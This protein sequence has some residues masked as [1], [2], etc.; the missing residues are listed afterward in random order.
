MQRYFGRLLDRQALLT[1]DDI[2]H[3]LHVMRQKE[4]A[5]FELVS[6]GS[7]FLCHILTITPFAAEVVK[8]LSDQRKGPDITL[9]YSLP[10]GEKLDL[11]LQKAT[12]LGVKNIILTLTA[13]SIVRMTRN[14]FM[15][16]R[17]RYE[18]IIKE[19]AEQSLRL[20]MPRLTFCEKLREAV[21]VT[22]GQK[23]IADT[24]IA[25]GKPLDVAIDATEGVALLI[26]PEGGFEHEEVELAK[27]FG[28]IPVSLGATI[29]RTETAVIAGLA[30]LAYKYAHASI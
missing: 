12:E 25:N 14:D 15:K 10:K 5:E 19:A 18:R 4:G 29:L 7:L 9:I 28:F 24:T 2:H 1:P 3:L 8:K 16:K 23:L 17:D 30:M 13:R 20:E 26:G 11:V 21:S 6:D 27:T 22:L